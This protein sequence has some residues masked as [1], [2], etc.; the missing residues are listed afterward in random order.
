M[1]LRMLDDTVN[2]ARGIARATDRQKTA[3]GSLLGIM[4]KFFQI[5]QTAKGSSV[6]T[7]VSAK[8]LD[9]L[10]EACKQTWNVLNSTKYIRHYQRGYVPLSAE[11]R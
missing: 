2:H 4:H 10:A 6:E 9:R 1:I 8:E 11:K 7:S 5:A 3:T